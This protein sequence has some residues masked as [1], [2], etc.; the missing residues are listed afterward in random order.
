[1]YFKKIFQQ[2]FWVVTF[3]L[4]ASVLSIEALEMADPGNSEDGRADVIQIQK[5]GN[6][7]QMPAAIFLH[8][9]HTAS[10]ANQD[11]STCHL[12]GNDKQY[13]FKF[14]RTV[15]FSYDV[16]MT[17]YHENCIGC[18]NRMKS[19]GKQAGPNTGQCRGCHNQSSKVATAWVDLPFDRS[20][21]YRHES[22]KAI[23]PVS[24]K[25]KDNCGA[26]H[27][28]Y[29]KKARKT[30]YVPGK[31]GACRYC[32][33]D[34]DTKDVRAMQ[35]VAHESCLNCHRTLKAKR[36]IKTG[37]TDCSGCHDAEM[38]ADIKQLES[39]PR[40]KRNQPDAVLMAASLMKAIKDKKETQVTIQPVAFN[41][42]QHET[43]E[44]NCQ[45]C[46][47]ASLEKC[48]SCHTITGDKKGQFVPLEKAIHEISS[49]KSC[50]GCHTQAQKKKDCAGCH[51]QM[52]T[53]KSNAETC[54]ACHNVPVTDF[55]QFPVK[56]DAQARMALSA[57]SSREMSPLTYEKKKVPEKISIGVMA[58]EYQAA[59]FPHEKVIKTLLERLNKDT[60][61]K[62]FHK[63]QYS[64]CQGCHHNSPKSASPPKCASCHGMTQTAATDDRP[65]LKGAYHRQCIGCHDE[66]GIEKP[67]ATACIECHKKKK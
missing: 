17:V 23:K 2:L 57:I 46:H 66:M 62:Y 39:V 11:C 12:K 21:H 18:H 9:L 61:G 1:M 52:A 38:Q 29:D 27:H 55:N 15:D 49:S 53:G 5:A 60:M 50:V 4:I 51:S 63:D 13:I 16:N 58:K 30:V 40:M 26:C 24:A 35:T 7:N 47:H 33:L 41:H 45:S 37:P 10:L 19:E 6:K 22:A 3:L 59:D 36:V 42:K 67:A 8:D 34:V 56:S 64:M 48:S 54:K 25:D 28:E 20:L 14:M 44:K 65:S 31:E 32:H 43:S